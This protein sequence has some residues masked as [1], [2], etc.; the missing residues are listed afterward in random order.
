VANITGTWDGTWSSTS[1]V[2]GGNVT[3]SFTLTG[4][5]VTGNGSLTGSPCFAQG[6]FGGTLSGTQL[7]VQ[8]VGAGGSIDFSATVDATGDNLFGDYVVIGGACAGDRGRWSAM[9]R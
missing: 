3:V 6:A 2:A 7:V 5:S 9:R 1:V 4:N 8:A